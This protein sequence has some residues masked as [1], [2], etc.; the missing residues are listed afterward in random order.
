MKDQIKFNTFSFISTFARS[1]IELFIALFLFKNGFSIKEVL[2][3]YLLEN[4]FAIFISYFFVKIGEKFK[5][6][7]VMYLGIIAFI[8]LQ[9]IINNLVN[10]YWYLILI[11]FVYSI[12]R[13]GYWVSRRYYI[14]NIMPQRNSS[15][16][17]SIIVVVS[18]LAS[19]IAGYIG[20]YLLDDLNVFI[21]TIISSILLVISVIPLITIKTKKENTKIELI[22]NLKT[23]DKRN[24]LAFSLYEI[25]NILTF[26]FPIYIALYIKDTYIMAG[27]INAIS[28][29]AIIIF[30]LIYGKLIKKRNYFVISSIL[31]III[32]LSKL[33]FINYFILI[34]YFLE[35]I[36]KK[37]QNQSVNKIYFENRNGMDLVHYNLIYQIIESVIRVLVTIPLLF[38]GDVRIMIVIV[39]IVISIELIIYAIMKK[40]KKL[41]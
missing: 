9:V 29:I 28:N 33:F 27:Y 18:E 7:T 10:S 6:S 14:T 40:G 4:F 23:Y 11:S 8:S 22:K 12:Y 35:G 25:T 21:L 41:N 39:M 38:V 16:K 5:Y 1:L 20:G 24:Y 32:T 30:I 17:F 31:F 15:D 26:L 2:V 37:M 19:I 13:R 36:I 34:F 3:F